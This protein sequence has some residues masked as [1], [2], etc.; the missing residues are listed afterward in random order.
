[1]SVPREVCILRPT[2]S[3]TRKARRRLLSLCATIVSSIIYSLPRLFG[4]IVGSRSKV[5]HSPPLDQADANQPICCGCCTCRDWEWEET[6]GWFRF[7]PT[8]SRLLYA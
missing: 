5:T 4:P 2:H 8:R 6:R 1:M 3:L 7:D